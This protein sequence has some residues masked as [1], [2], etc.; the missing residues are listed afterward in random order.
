M[1][2]KQPRTPKILRET[3]SFGGDP[4]KDPIY[5]G[6]G[7]WGTSSGRNDLG[8]GGGAGGGANGGLQVGGIMGKKTPR[9]IF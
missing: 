9:G 4:S 3:K 6:V 2:V 5:G 8:D 1:E 7:V